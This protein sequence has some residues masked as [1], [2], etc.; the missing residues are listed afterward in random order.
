VPDAAAWCQRTQAGQVVKFIGGQLRP[1]W[2]VQACTSG[3][4]V[5]EPPGAQLLAASGIFAYC[6]TFDVRDAVAC[7]RT[8]R[9]SASC[10]DSEA[11]L[12][13][14]AVTL[15]GERLILLAPSGREMSG[16]GSSPGSCD[17]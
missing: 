11:G 13:P 14:R 4:E 10:K 9:N 15:D 6:G 5:L 17:E 12:D 2:Q 7:S 8:T 3:P 1:R 16:S